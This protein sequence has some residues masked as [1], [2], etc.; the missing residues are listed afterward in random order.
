[1]KLKNRIIACGVFSSC[2]LTLPVQAAT[3]EVPR[4][5]E[6]MYVDLEGAREFGN[7][8][9]VNIDEGQ[10]QIVVRFN[11]LVR[12]GGDTQAYQSQP[13]VLDLQFEKN[14]YFTVKAPYISTQKQ[15]ESYLK[16]PTFTLVDDRSGK[17]VDYQHQILPV[18]SG[19]Q[20]TRDYITEIERLTAKSTP[21]L[22]DGPAA[23]PVIST[24]NVALEMM[25]FWYNRSDEATRKDMR[26]WIA[27]DLYKP[28]VSNIQL[29]M[30]QFWFNKA[31]RE[32]KKAFQAWLVE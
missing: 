29:E 18:K 19:F 23:A 8:F 4:S 28:T 30:L 7:D 17:A 32:A 27:D 14:D 9:K 26:I 12:S 20:N 16:N 5:F 15:A 2:V 3:F 21:T 10:H 24:S 31:D 22:N 11:K 6:I 1:M 25:Q 13:I